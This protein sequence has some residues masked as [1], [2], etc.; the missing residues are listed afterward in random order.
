MNVPKLARKVGVMPSA[1][2]PS[3]LGEKKPIALNHGMKVVA[4]VM[5]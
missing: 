1:G 2:A 4:W 3:P 5:K